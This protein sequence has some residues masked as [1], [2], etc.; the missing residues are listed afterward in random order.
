LDVDWFKQ[1]NDIYGHR[2]G[3]DCLR[4]IAAL[5][6]Q[7]PQRTGDLVARYG[8]EELVVLLPQTSLESAALIAERIRADIVALDILHAASPLTIVTVSAGVAM[9][10]PSQESGEP[11][12]L[13]E[14]ADRALYVAKAKGRNYVARH[15]DARID[16]AFP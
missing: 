1:Y 6:K 13:V 3:D 15:D 14:E 9:I 12:E 8:G 11:E 4:R 16:N 2:A 7:V 10:E 5:L